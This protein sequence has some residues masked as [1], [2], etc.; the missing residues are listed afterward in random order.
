MRRT[1][2]TTSGGSPG[3]GENEAMKCRDCDYLEHSTNGAYRCQLGGIQIAKNRLDVDRPCP[4]LDAAK[5]KA[6]GKKGELAQALNMPEADAIP[7]L[8]PVA[9]NPENVDQETPEE[10][11][12]AFGAWLEAETWRNEE[13][14]K[15]L[16]AVLELHGKIERQYGIASP[17]AAEMLQTL[18]RVTERRL[19]ALKEVS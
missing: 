8:C 17:D 16:T 1:V 6:E 12:K 9:E 14:R 2:S 3:K 11:I 15:E 10:V 19:A 13:S 4:R 18:R 7:T 5:K